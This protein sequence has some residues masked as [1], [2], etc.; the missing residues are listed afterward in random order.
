MKSKGM[1][2]SHLSLSKYGASVHLVM[3]NKAKHNDS[4]QNKVERKQ[5]G[6]WVGMC[7]L[8][9]IDSITEGGAI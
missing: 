5:C 3:Q 8:M 6:M 1:A 7:T 2:A 9:G 4:L